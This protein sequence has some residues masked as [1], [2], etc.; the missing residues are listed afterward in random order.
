[1]TKKCIYCKSEV[2]S[3]SVIDFCERCGVGVWGEKMFREIVK[4]METARDNGDLCHT[5]APE[6]ALEPKQETPPF[7]GPRFY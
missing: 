6:K 3:E 4:N 2:S 7:E 1:M 5:P